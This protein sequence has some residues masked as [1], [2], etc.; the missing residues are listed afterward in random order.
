MVEGGTNKGLV[1]SL[2]TTDVF[3][4]QC[5]GTTVKYLKNGAV[6]YSSVVSSASGTPF[7]FDCVFDA[8]TTS[9]QVGLSNCT[10]APMGPAGSS[11]WTPAFGGDAG[12]HQDQ[13]DRPADS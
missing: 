2:V 11:S 9:G 13:L 7:Y 3:A 4:V 5:N 10:F 8:S 1:A 6:L 12:T